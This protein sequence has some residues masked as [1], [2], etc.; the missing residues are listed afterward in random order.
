MA[1][2]F[3]PTHFSFQTSKKE[4]SKTTSKSLDNLAFEPNDE[5]IDFLLNYSKS[6]SII[7]TN[8]LGC[9]DHIGN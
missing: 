2:I 5:T 6:L 7:H 1:K 3:T 9:I 4:K 8:T